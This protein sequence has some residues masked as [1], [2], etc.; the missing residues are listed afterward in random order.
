MLSDQKRT[1]TVVGGD[2]LNWFYHR[3]YRLVKKEIR[4]ETLV[5][6]ESLFAAWKKFSSGK[7]RTPSVREFWLALEANLRELYTQLIAGKYRHGSYYHFL[8]SDPKRRDIFVPTVRDRI[9]HQ[10]LSSL[11]EQIYAP[12]FFRHSYAAQREKG[13][14]AARTYAL[15]I[16]RS[17]YGHGHVFIGKL[18][19]K[20]YFA[21][22]NHK[23][24]LSCLR[25]IIPDERIVTL[26]REVLNSFGKGSGV[27][28][29]NLTSQW[30]G[31]IYLHELDHYIKHTLHI[32][33]YLRYNDDLIIF[34]QEIERVRA[35]IGA[36]RDFAG[37]KLLLSMPE[38]KI[39]VVHLPDT[40]DILGL[41]TDGHRTWLR[42]T[43]IKRAER[44]IER[45]VRNNDPA[46]Y[47]QLCSYAGMGIII[48]GEIFLD[49]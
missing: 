37:Q 19:V 40:I 25:R 2:F 12:L 30:F 39:S 13:M 15:K 16:I 49:A 43:S 33:Y 26:F 24:L 32:R 27:P 5:T 14:H 38:K 21:N 4:F 35:W 3:T 42:P 22:I 20:K 28:L 6:R 36:I 44:T 8:V 46:L 10:L 7:W 11:L 18:D 48:D 17:L 34:S 1:T 47:D 45:S 23:I 31:N 9:V 29:G 41:R